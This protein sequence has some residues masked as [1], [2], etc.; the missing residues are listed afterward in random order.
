LKSICDAGLAVIYENDG[1]KYIQLLRWKEH[2]RTNS[3][4][5]E[6]PNEVLHSKCTANAQQMITSPPSPSPSPS[7]SPSPTP[8]PSGAAG[9]E[10]PEGF[11]TTESE[12][13]EGASLVAVP[14]SFVTDTWHKANSRGGRDAKG[15]PIVNFNSY[16]RTEWKYEQNRIGERNGHADAEK[17]KGE[18]EYAALGMKWTLS[19]GGPQESEFKDPGNFRAFRDAF[20]RWK[21]RQENQ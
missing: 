9:R 4:F 16:L 19:S 20:T 1:N 7:L 11:P 8:T 15:N 6:C 13:I 10:A 2:A 21:E 12:A 17:P 5:P 3:K 18:P 14:P